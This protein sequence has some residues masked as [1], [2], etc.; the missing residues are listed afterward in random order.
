MKSKMHLLCS[1]YKKFDQPDT[2]KLLLRIMLGGILI[3]HGAHKLIYGIDE[4]REMLAAS[5]LPAFLGY[6]V[7]AGELVAPVLL[8]AGILTRAA[9]LFIMINMVFAWYLGDAPETLHLDA[10][11]GLMIEGLLFYFFSA[12][13]VIFLGAGKYAVIKNS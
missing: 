8:L 5:G 6:G 1:V 13:A 4:V 2:G 7:Y 9:A 11:G 10:Q 3:F 12:I